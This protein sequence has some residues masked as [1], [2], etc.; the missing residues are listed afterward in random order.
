MRTYIID[1]YGR[2][3]L[4]CIEC[5]FDNKYVKLINLDYLDY[6]EEPCDCKHGHP[7]EK[8]Y[9]LFFKILISKRKKKILKEGE[10]FEFEEDR[11]IWYKSEQGA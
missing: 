5:D 9:P 4:N 7:P 2:A 11:G 6:K 3:D 1:Y 8:L 10:F